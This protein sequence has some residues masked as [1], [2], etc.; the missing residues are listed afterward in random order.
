VLQIAPSGYRR[1]VA[2]QRTPELRCARAKQD[3]TLL[4]QIHQVWQNNMQVYGADK[5]WHQLNREGVAV[6]RCTVERLMRLSNLRG[7]RRGKVVRTTIGDRAVPCPLDRVNRQ[8]KADRPNQ[9]WVSDFTYVSTW[10][11][12]QYVA[13]V[14]DVYA[15]PSFH[16]SFRL[17]HVHSSA[18]PKPIYNPPSTLEHHYWTS[19]YLRSSSG[20]FKNI[21]LNFFHPV[22]AA[23]QSLCFINMLYIDGSKSVNCAIHGQKCN[24]PKAQSTRL[25][26]HLPQQGCTL[27]RC[28]Q[29]C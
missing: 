29:R 4:P 7:V 17:F 20:P 5:V 15:R 11:G 8:F 9:L 16:H 19:K 6:A 14:I 3:E 12:W 27:P 22:F 18:Y 13:F 24:S 10:Q 26:P 2:Q 25:R 1:H 23:K 28:I 21:F